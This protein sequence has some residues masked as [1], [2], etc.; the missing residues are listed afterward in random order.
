MTD[1][2]LFPRRCDECRKGMSQ[3][4]VFGDCDTFCDACAFDTE[5][6]RKAF[7]D[8]YDEEGDSYYTEWEELDDLEN[9]L[10]D[11]TPV[12]VTQQS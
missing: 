9:Y 3:G 7:E 5:A 4:Y 1:P 2:K 12:P 8:N 10:A 11:G 6:D